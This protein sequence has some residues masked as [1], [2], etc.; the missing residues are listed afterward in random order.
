VIGVRAGEA[1][2]LQPGLAQAATAALLD[3]AA[4]GHLRPHIAETLPLSRFAEGMRRLMD[5]RAIGRV[6]LLP[7]G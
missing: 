2:R 3:L 7:G 5:R 1:S 6:I 4:A